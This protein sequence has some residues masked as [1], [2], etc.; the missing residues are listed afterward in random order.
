MDE[1]MNALNASSTWKL[2]PLSKEKM[3]EINQ[4]KAQLSLYSK[5]VGRLQGEVRYWQ[6][7]YF[8][9]KEEVEKLS[10]DLGIRDKVNFQ[11]PNSDRS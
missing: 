10:L 3:T 7:A 11:H 5:E 2:T 4:L 6:D 1:E 8:K 9:M